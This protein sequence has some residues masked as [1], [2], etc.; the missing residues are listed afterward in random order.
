M[1]ERFLSIHHLPRGALSVVMQYS[2]IVWSKGMRL[3]GISTLDAANVYLEEE[4]LE[5]MNA[6]FH[7]EARSPEDVHRSVP[8]GINLDHVLYY[9]ESRVV[10]NDW[11][12][13]WCN[14]ILQLD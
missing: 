6:R 5:E 3:K 10:Q 7:V 14:R 9:E 12:V 4:F 13:S 2:R 1:V 11:T 8:R